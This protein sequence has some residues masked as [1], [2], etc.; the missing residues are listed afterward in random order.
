MDHFAERL[1][2]MCSQDHRL[3]ADRASRKVVFMPGWSAFAESSEA[4]VAVDKLGLVWPGTEPVASQTLEKIG[5]KR[6]C[7]AVGAPT[8]PFVVLSEEDAGVDLTD[9]AAKE[10]CVA[11]FMQAVADMKSN[12]M[13]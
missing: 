2:W 11:G 4:A 13:G 1:N 5:F 7:A 6:I 9:P 10:K 8:P 12:E 3:N